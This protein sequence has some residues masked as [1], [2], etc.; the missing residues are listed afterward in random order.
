M[1]RGASGYAL[2]AS[3]VPAG[4]QRRARLRFLLEY[5]GPYRDRRDLSRILVEMS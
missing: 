3:D 1:Q 5:H 4:A 2:P